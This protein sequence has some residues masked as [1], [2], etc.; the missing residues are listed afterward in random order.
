MIAALLHVFPELQWDES[1]FDNIRS[2]LEREGNGERIGRE[3]I[4]AE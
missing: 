4:S 2:K 1:K 3:V